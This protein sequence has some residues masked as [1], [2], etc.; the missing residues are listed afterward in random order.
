MDTVVAVYAIFMVG[1]M[2]IKAM[3]VGQPWR[4]IVKIS[5]STMFVAVGLHYV[6]NNG[7]QQ[8]QILLFVA[9][10]FAWIGDAFLLCK[11]KVKMFHLGCLAFAFSNMLLTSHAVLV[12]TWQWWSLVLFAVF[13]ATMLICQKLNVFS[14]GH[15]KLVL[16]LYSLSVGY[17][18]L[19]GLTIAIA[20]GTPSAVMFGVGSM[21][22]LAS[23]F[24]LALFMFKFKKWPMDVFNTL[25]YFSGM[26]L[27]A[28]SIA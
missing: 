4:A 17:N 13:V 10:V 15:S 24:A 18:G 25:L 12:Y 7:W 2:L 20:V 28:F 16:N 11:N 19:L 3:G 14:F 22:F 21:L 26:M 23:D 27:L 9:L 6:A 5:L 8:A 1:Y